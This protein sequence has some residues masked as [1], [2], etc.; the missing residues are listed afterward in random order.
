MKWIA[1]EMDLSPST[2]SR[3][4]A[5]S[6]GDSSRLT[7][8]DLERFMEVTGDTSPIAYLV[9]KFLANRTDERIAELEA[10]L[11][12]LRGVGRAA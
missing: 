12:A 8:A 3:K 6:P 1:A 9:E 2:L 11:A 5:E 10:Q 7:V 4:L